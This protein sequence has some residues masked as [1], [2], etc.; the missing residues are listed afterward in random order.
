MNDDD[1]LPL[2]SV[3]VVLGGPSSPWEQPLRALAREVRRVRET[4][5]DDGL[6]VNVVFYAPGTGFQPDFQGA[7]SGTFSRRHGRLMIQVGLPEFSE[8]F[9]DAVLREFASAIEKAE[10]FARAEAL[11]P[12]SALLEPHSTMVRELRPFDSM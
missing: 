11:I 3:G 4:F 5:P 12:V 9:Q 7:R 10:N 2:L 8:D 1:D 6:R